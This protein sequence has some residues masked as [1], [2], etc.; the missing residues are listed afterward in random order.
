MKR[1]ALA[2]L[3]VA[4]G[5]HKDPMPVDIPGSL[6]L[7]LPTEAVGV[8]G[9]P[10]RLNFESV[11]LTETPDAY[12][13]EVSGPGTA[14]ATHW[15]W[16]PTEAGTSTFDLTVRDA[17]AVVSHGTMAVRVLP[18]AATGTARIL[19]VGDSGTYSDGYPVRLGARLTAAGASWTF[20]GPNGTAP[21]SHQGEG[22]RTYA[23]YA[24]LR[25]DVWTTPFDPDGGNDVDVDRYIAE[26]LGGIVPTHVIFE[27]AVNDV[28]S[29]R[30]ANPEDDDVFLTAAETLFGQLRAAMPYAQFGAMLTT[31]GSGDAAAWLSNYPT[32][33]GQR[34]RYKQLQH[35]AVGR[36]L[37]AWQGR[38]AARLRVLPAQMVL[39]PDVDFLDGNALHWNLTGGRTAIGD[40][41][42][43]WVLDTLE[44][45]DVAGELTAT[46]SQPGALAPSRTAAAVLATSR[47]TPA[48]LTITRTVDNE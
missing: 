31:T 11:V 28:F 30:V 7:Q 27:L 43:N 44:P 39:D 8:V 19:L 45:A 33:T 13:Y 18:A 47:A 17:G 20:L 36:E 2:L 48:T 46:R 42:A 9:T 21:Y 40:V 3:L 41:F 24:G 4:C 5:P 38:E 29:N 10:M 37:A 15:T 23:A 14:D 1:L 6:Q 26:T 12:D 16:T 35:R 22:G 25:P 32:Y 34:W